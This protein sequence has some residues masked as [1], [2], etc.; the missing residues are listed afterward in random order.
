[1]RNERP[2]LSSSTQEWL[3]EEQNPSVRFL[4][5]KNLLGK[6]ENDP[7]V[8]AARAGI[9]ER[10]IVPKILELQNKNGYWV[11]KDDFYIRTKYRGTV[12]Q[13]IIL[14]ELNA[15]GS[16]KRIKKTT[17]YLTTISQDRQSGGFAYDGSI[18]NGGH[19]SKVIPCLT[20]NIA[21]SLIRFGYLD[22]PRTQRAIDW[23]TSFQRFD[24]GDSSPP[25]EW[26]YKNFMN[27]WGKHTC[28]MGVVKSL[29]A[30][31]E[32]PSHKRRGDV[33]KI[34]ERGAEFL[35]SHHLF[36]RSHDL[37]RVAKASWTQFGYPLLWQTDALEMLGVLT[38][39]VSEDDRM[40]ETF[41]L[42]HT[43]CNPEG[44][45]LLDRTF[46]GKFQV[47]IERKGKPSKWITFHCLK[48]LT[49]NKS[50]SE[51]DS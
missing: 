9:M 49:H 50:L 25:S 5:L 35:L 40:R 11:N 33:S 46:N 36:K 47:N 15:D 29:K 34:L 39:I 17:E 44:R 7:D 24:D 6:K 48:A 4:T 3:L 16:D 19:H 31:A 13:Y 21:W 14:A 26:P 51:N 37:C 23:I 27:C 8:C 38:E 45:W 42:I 28:H 1:V 32:I 10:G 2:F 43:K 41:D 30:L 12:W 20:G 22:D 18:T